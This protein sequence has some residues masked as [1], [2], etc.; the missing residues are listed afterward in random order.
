MNRLKKS[1]EIGARLMRF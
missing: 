1:I